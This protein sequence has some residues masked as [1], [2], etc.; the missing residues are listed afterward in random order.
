MF[1]RTPTTCIPQDNNM[2][3]KF[4]NRRYIPDSCQGDSIVTSLRRTKVFKIKTLNELYNAI[5]VFDVTN[6]YK[7]ADRTLRSLYYYAKHYKKICMASVR[8]GC[9]SN[10]YF[11]SL[12]D[13]RNWW[14][15]VIIHGDAYDDRLHGGALAVVMNGLAHESNVRNGT[16]YPM[17]RE[18]APSETWYANGHILRMDNGDNRKWD[19]QNIQKQQYFQCVSIGDD[20]TDDEFGENETSNDAGIVAEDVCPWI[21]EMLT[22]VTVTRQIKDCDL[23]INYRDFPLC[24]I[25]GTPAYDSCLVPRQHAHEPPPSDLVV[26]MSVCGSYSEFADVPMPNQD[27]WARMKS[28]AMGLQTL[29]T[30]PWRSKINKAVFRGSSTGPGVSGNVDD[31]FVNTRMRLAR[32]S[33]ERPDLLDAGITK[34]NLRPRVVRIADESHL[35]VP[36]RLVA[37]PALKKPMT[38]DEQSTYKYI[39]HV[40]GH[41]A[42]FR[43]AAEMFCESVI[44]KCSSPW[45]LWYSE[46]L[47]PY[48]HYV[49]VSSDLRDLYEKIEWCR[50]NDE[51]CE[52]IAQNA[53]R[54]AVQYLCRYSMM[55]TLSSLINLHGVSPTA[56]IDDG[57]LRLMD[58]DVVLRSHCKSIALRK[59]RH[60]TG[61]RCIAP[62]L[63]YR[64]DA[65]YSVSTNE[66]I[67]AMLCDEAGLGRYLYEGGTS[68]R[69]L[70]V[71][72]FTEK[73]VAVAYDN[74]V[75]FS[76]KSLIVNSHA[77][78][79]K[80]LDAVQYSTSCLNMLS[81]E[82][83]TVPYTMLSITKRHPV[84][85][86]M[87]CN[88]CICTEY[89]KNSKTLIEFLESEDASQEAVVEVYVQIYLCL[90]LMYERHGRGHGNLCDPTN[91][92]VTSVKSSPFYEYSFV[93]QAFGCV[94]MRVRNVAIVINAKHGSDLHSTIN[95][96]WRSIYIPKST[97]VNSMSQHVRNYISHNI[98][99]LSQ[100][101]VIRNTVD[102][103]PSVFLYGD[104]PLRNGVD[105][106][107][108]AVRGGGVPWYKYSAKSEADMIY[109]IRKTAEFF[110]NISRTITHVR[111]EDALDD[112]TKRKYVNCLVN[113]YNR[114][115]HE[116]KSSELAQACRG[117]K[118]EDI[119]GDPSEAERR[120][121]HCL[122][123]P[124]LTS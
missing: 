43:L 5:R 119:F 49:P 115:L 73:T 14:R 62:R 87:G 117:G 86:E 34:W 60:T 65:R 95:D 31:T 76:L 51:A 78:I 32:M 12:Q 100:P 59:L 16:R 1:K 55:N 75:R 85:D 74:G 29:R 96:E 7:T 45:R 118:L 108:E 106:Y 102:M 79:A 88:I 104:V 124:P 41:V 22:E 2:I 93:S 19:G 69:P 91:I 3:R 94:T 110:I 4:L 52:T 97:C 120:L 70:G 116:M 28:S 48:V 27:D 15:P 42:A 39:V 89:I 50:N 103:L 90:R 6:E 82:I 77:D 17:I 122:G 68:L 26:P 13:Y 38:Y 72:H 107:L 114:Y 92:L 57:R 121:A 99:N 9:L 23:I 8:D 18:L 25:D 54:L 11:V 58:P 64:Y 36:D 105:R 47:Q 81:R 111:C 71:N 61:Y 37:E 10:V 109:T 123:A 35:I 53:K 67:A 84:S 56:V 113:I 101:D 24:K 44:L 30:I 83:P 63:I 66:S 21:V 33:V 40:D 20:N 46:L 98:K 112:S 80:V